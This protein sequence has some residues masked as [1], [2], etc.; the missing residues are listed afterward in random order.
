MPVDWLFSEFDSAILTHVYDPILM[1]VVTSNPMI[2]TQ[3]VK[4]LIIKY[5]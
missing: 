1:R 2:K 3:K 5:T 4:I